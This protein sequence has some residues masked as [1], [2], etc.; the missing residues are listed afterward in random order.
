MPQCLQVHGISATHNLYDRS[1]CIFLHI[2]F[3][4]LSCTFLFQAVDEDSGSNGDLT[5]TL[6]SSVQ[7][8][9][10]LLETS[11]FSVQ[12]LLNHMLDRENTDSYSF[13]VFAT[14]GG[15]PGLVGETEIN[16]NVLVS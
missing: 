10:T 15:S 13:R 11:P 2:R 12:V 7:G 1:Q 6:E 8:L 5:F 16:I 14:D 9:F 3:L 4:K